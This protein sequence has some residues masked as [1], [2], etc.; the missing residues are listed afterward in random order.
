MKKII[1]FVASLFIASVSYAQMPSMDDFKSPAENVPSKGIVAPEEIQKP[2]SIKI[3]KKVLSRDGSTTTIVK[4]AKTQDAINKAVEIQQREMSDDIIQIKVGSGIGIVARGVA[5]YQKYPN[6]RN[7]TLLLQRQAYVKAFMFAKKNLA[8]Y[9]YG[10][11][12]GAKQELI[13]SMEQIDTDQNSLVNSNDGMMETNE[14]KLE[15]LLKGFVIYKI[16]DDP[17]E[18]LVTVSI[19]TTPKT[20]GET[21]QANSGTVVAKDFEIAMKQ[22]LAKIKKGVLPPLGGKVISVP[23]K[24]QLFFV[25]YGSEIIRFNS[26]KSIMRKN[27][28]LAVKIAKMRAK[29]ALV[30][31]IIGDQASW[32]GNFSQNTSEGLKQFQQINEE[33]P[34]NKRGSVDFKSIGTTHSN[35]LN[36]MKNTDTYRFAQ[37]GQL[38]PGLNS[39]SWINGDW[40][41][42]LYMYNPNSTRQANSI[43]EKMQAPGILEKSNES[44]S[45]TKQGPS[46]EAGRDKPTM[47]NNQLEIQRGPSGQI[48]RDNEL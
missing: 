5:E 31:L 3:S 37:K 36:R 1:I 28:R 39:H 41:Y 44:S 6:N 13:K 27:K 9:L 40:A 25:G 32:T 29:K 21:M 8:E 17:N 11:S 15:G 33:D 35:Y 14:Q 48:S 10:L 45:T 12:D 2:D 24:K 4:A 23:S 16:N 42:A 22:V 47:E 26:N 18:H 46:L 34:L 30:A 20:R 38:P 19:V 7:A 43:K